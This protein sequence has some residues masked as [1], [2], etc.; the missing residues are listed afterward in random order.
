MCRIRRGT[1]AVGLALFACSTGRAADEWSGPEITRKF[2]RHEREIEKIEGLVTDTSSAKHR[3]GALEEEVRLLRRQVSGL[4]ATLRNMQETLSTMQLDIAKSAMVRDLTSKAGAART[5]EPT[6]R[7]TAPEATAGKAAVANSR[8]EREGDFSVITG[9][10][11][12]QTD[13]PLTF[14]I[15]RADF[16]DAR[17]NVVKSES[18]YT[19]P[20]IIGP[21]G[22]AS[23]KINT[24]R[25][26]RVRQHRLTVETR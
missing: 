11:E 8:V 10:V 14:V 25:D 6:L 2:E 7:D 5:G 1:L 20:R 13:E 18:V 22:Q 3:I 17:G 9:T 19:S 4:E 21:R 15:V 16:L 26:H 23:F 24:R 12:N